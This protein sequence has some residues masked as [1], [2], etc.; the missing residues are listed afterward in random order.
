MTYYAL[1]ILIEAFLIAPDYPPYP[2]FSNAAIS[3]W[4]FLTACSFF[5]SGVPLSSP[6][7]DSVTCLASLQRGLTGVHPGGEMSF[8]G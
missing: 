3:S 5:L 4:S 1:S 6:R 7:A 2:V 8:P